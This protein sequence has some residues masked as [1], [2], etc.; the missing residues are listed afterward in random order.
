MFFV[1]N[2]K[3]AIEE[4]EFWEKSYQPRSTTP[5]KLVVADFASDFPPS[6]KEKKDITGRASI[7]LSSLTVG[8]EETTKDFQLCPFFI[9]DTAK[10]IIS[11]GKSLQLIRHA[12]MTSL[13]AASADDVENGYN[14]AGFTLSEIFC[15][16]LTALIGHG[17][18]VA[19]YL[20]QDDKN[21]LGST[22]DSQ[23]VCEIDRSLVA[24][25]ESKKFWQ[26]LLDDT[27]AHKRNLGLVST[28]REGAIDH[29]NLKGMNTQSGEIDILP[30]TYCPENPSISVCHGILEENRD[31]WSSLN[32]S[33]A[34]NLPPLN[35][36]W[37]RQAIFSDN[38]GHGLTMDYT[39]AFQFGELECSKFMEDAKVLEAVLPFPTLLPSFKV[40]CS[41]FS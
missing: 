40:F 12:P 13:L 23:E 28:S 29:H 4:A 19:E 41:L 36:E 21:F 35:D 2:K 32:I 30:Q 6:A 15:V 39:S 37:L 10:A 7:S 14:I 18:H 33:Q 8:K 24:N 20:S 3:I 27:L 22:K 34:F 25:A 11:A 5:E 16:S 9:K 17:D 38:C 1:A 26:K 31:A